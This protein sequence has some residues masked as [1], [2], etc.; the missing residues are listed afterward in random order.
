MPV[1]AGMQATA[2][3]ADQQNALARYSELPKYLDDEIANL[4][5]GLRLGYTAPKAQRP[6]GHRPDGRAAEGAGRRFAVR[7][8]G[9]NRTRRRS[10]SSSKSSR[11]RRFVRRSQRYRDFLRDVYLPAAR[12]AIG[13]SANPDGAACYAAAVKY[14]ATVAMTPQQVHDLGSPQMEKIQSEMREIGQRSFKPDDPVQAARARENGS[15]VPIQEPGRADQVRR[16]GGRAREG[17]RCR[18]RSAASRRPR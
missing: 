3:P 6:L 4:R 13:V 18:R 9:Q 7:A 15:A 12:E 11:N 17:R 5:E 14:H 10:A 8:D 1:I 2:T 16:S